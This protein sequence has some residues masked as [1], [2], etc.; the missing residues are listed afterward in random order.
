MKE[1]FPKKL[2]HN[3]STTISQ[4]SLDGFEF[5]FHTKLLKAYGSVLKG[6]KR[7]FV[8]SEDPTK[9]SKKL[10]LFFWGHDSF[11]T[12][13]RIKKGKKLMRYKSIA[14][15]AKRVVNNG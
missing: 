9:G 4:L 1:E 8:S 14:P 6:L 10:F 5:R 2:D 13:I 11:T 3:L 7:I 12:R 15:Q